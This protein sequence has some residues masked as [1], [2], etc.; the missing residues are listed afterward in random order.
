[1]EQCRPVLTLFS[2]PKP[3]HGHIDL[4]Q[5][6]AI[7][8]WMR[9][10]P[11]CEIILCGDDEGV[12]E[13]AKEFGLR[14]LPDVARNEHG[15]PLVNDLFEQ[16]ERFAPHNLLCYVNADIILMSDFLNGI[17]RVAN[18]FERPFLMVGQRWDV[19][20]KTPLEFTR[21]W[22]ARLRE[23]VRREGKLHGITGMDYF[24]FRKGL[25]GII[26]PF[27]IGRTSWDNWLIYGARQRGAAVIDATPSVMIVH[28]QHDYGHL[29][30]GEHEAWHGQEAQRNFELTGGVNCLFNLHDA[31][32]CLTPSG[33]S[34]HISVAS[35]RQSL[36]RRVRW[37]DLNGIISKIRQIMN[38]EGIGGCFEYLVQHGRQKMCAYW[39]SC[40]A[41]SRSKK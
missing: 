7:Q 32:H 15:T 23:H 16:A 13:V 19:D 30:G 3:F 40:R 20:I 29:A 14:H 27:G 9:L 2:L 18:A 17:E 24:A 35:I 21:D 28:Q 37:H 6:N 41:K 25:W 8:S 4:I 31:T 1:M 12:A 34:K 38:D 22:D 39:C 10:T 33:I 26:P 11:V 5:R 36:T